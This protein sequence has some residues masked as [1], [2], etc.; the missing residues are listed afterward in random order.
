MEILIVTNHPDS[1]FLGKN[2]KFFDDIKESLKEKPEAAIISNVTSL[3]MKT[4]I[5]LAKSGIHIFIE[6][7]LSHSM[8]NITQ[9]LSLVKKKNLVTLIGCNMR[10]HPCI[11]KINEIILHNDVGKILFVRVENGSYL[12]DWHPYEDYRNSY[13]ARKD[14]GGGVVLTNIHEI[15]YLFWFFGNVKDVFSITSKH[16][17]LQITAEDISSTILRFNN[18]VIAEIH[19]D[20]FQRP[21]FRGCK[22]VGTKG[23]IMWDA[24]MNKVKVYHIKNKKWLTKLSLKK[25]N[26]NDMYVNEMAHFI[27]SVK[28]KQ[29]TVNT[30]YDGVK[31]LEIALAIKKSSKIKRMVTL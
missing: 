9:L 12:P 28:L 3:H 25:Y 15:D 7:P 26:N 17:N 27:K 14:L 22:I 1:N 24:N 18:D 23:T 6:K 29:K 21:S 31:T 4:A 30:V 20:Y 8:R 13:A 5:I 10:F 19:L 16:S 11:K 2:C